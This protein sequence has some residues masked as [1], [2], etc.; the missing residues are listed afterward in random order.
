MLEADKMTGFV[1]VPNWWGKQMAVELWPCAEQSVS[2]YYCALVIFHHKF[3]GSDCLV[4]S[5]G[6]PG[7]RWR[8]GC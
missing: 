3:A 2:I 5:A 4:L 7:M 6:G 1:K 8:C